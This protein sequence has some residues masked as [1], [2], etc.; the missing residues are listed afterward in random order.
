LD[1]WAGRLNRNSA[2]RFTIGK[3]PYVNTT[4][5][6]AATLR[7]HPAQAAQHD[8]LAKYRDYTE[9]CDAKA[10]ALSVVPRVCSRCCRRVWVSLSPRQYFHVKERS[11][12]SN[13]HKF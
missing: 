9:F 11:H 5:P 10:S 13:V 6:L 12:V 2:A 1:C 7:N 3:L 8:I 4:L